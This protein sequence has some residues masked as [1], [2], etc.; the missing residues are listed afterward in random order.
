V[1]WV[2]GNKEAAKRVWQEALKKIPNDPRI[3][4]VM[5]RLTQ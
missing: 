1:L 4:K 3:K 2:S 5:Q